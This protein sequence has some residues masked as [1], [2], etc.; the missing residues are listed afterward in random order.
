MGARPPGPEVP[1]HVGQAA[2]AAVATVLV[3][4]I[5][6][7]LGRGERGGGAD[8]SRPAVNPGSNQPD[9]AQPASL[10]T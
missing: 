9:V 5:L 10:A 3:V 7:C 1:L 8:R 6:A 4:V 2:V